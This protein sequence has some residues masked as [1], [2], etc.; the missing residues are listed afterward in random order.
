MYF[1]H[2]NIIK[3]VNF[4]SIYR[5]VN[6]NDGSFFKAFNEFDSIFLLNIFLLLV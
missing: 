5:V 6:L 4:E 3:Y 2:H 1:S